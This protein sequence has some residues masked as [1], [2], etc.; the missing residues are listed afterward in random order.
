MGRDVVCLCYHG[1]SPDWP[2]D[3]AVT[4]AQLEHQLAWLLERGFTATTFTRA[5][6]D[7][8]ARRTLAVTF[9]DAYASVIENALPI[10]AALGIPATVFAPTRFMDAR[11]QLLWPG[12]DHWA[13]TPHASELRSMSWEDLRRLQDE[14]WEIGSHTRSH[15]HLDELGE[16]EL[17][18]ELKDSRERC[19]ERL[20]VDCVSIAYPYG[21]ASLRVAQ[22]AAHAGYRAAAT[23]P[24]S[25]DGIGPLLYPRI[26]VYQ[27]D[28]LRRFQMK[29]RA[30]GLYGSSIWRGVRSL[31]GR[32]EATRATY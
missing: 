23:I 22:A 29:I 7:P 27:V 24:P 21:T 32:R 18:A 3:M 14:G 5:V 26:G 31:I 15:P 4:P 12:I 16:G 28:N 25:R 13:S 1:V 10:L 19:T 30:R 11:Q 20:G 17:M 6:L 2:S 8:P 9:D